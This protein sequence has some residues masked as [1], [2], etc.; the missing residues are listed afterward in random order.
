MDMRRSRLPRVLGCVT[1]QG[2]AGLALPANASPSSVL[3][4]GTLKSDAGLLLAGSRSER[5]TTSRPDANQRCPMMTMDN[6]R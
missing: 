3:H 4:R 5:A 6:R 1:S 2:T